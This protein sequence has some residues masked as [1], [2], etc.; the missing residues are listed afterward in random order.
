MPAMTSGG[1]TAGGGVVPVG[2]GVVPVGGGVVP[3]G[4][5]VG[6]GDRVV[7]LDCGGWCV[8]VWCVGVVVCEGW[9][10]V[11][12]VVCEGWWCVRVVVCEGWCRC[13]HRIVNMAV[14]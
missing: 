5:G 4:K 1:S 3:V 8:C 12:V 2:K 14:R 7:E 10:C 11:G 13:M 6:V 9:W